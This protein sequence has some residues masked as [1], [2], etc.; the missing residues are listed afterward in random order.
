M[1]LGIGAWLILAPPG[2]EP[3]ASDKDATRLQQMVSAFYVGVAALDA[4]DNVGAKTNLS[5]R[6]IS[7]LLGSVLR[8]FCG[9]ANHLVMRQVGSITQ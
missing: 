1:A 2:D 3:V 4:D 7:N 6:A 9:I 5:G 8:A